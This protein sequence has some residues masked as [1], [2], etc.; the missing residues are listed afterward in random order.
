MFIYVL[1]LRKSLHCY[2]VTSKE[3]KEIGGLKGKHGKNLFGTLPEFGTTMEPYWTIR[4]VLLEELEEE[5]Y[6]CFLGL[7]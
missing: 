5:R 6:V 4:R 3:C 1:I 7:L 2:L